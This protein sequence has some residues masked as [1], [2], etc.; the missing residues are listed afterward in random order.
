MSKVS[1]NGALEK[2]GSVAVG[3]NAPLGSI[4]KYLK[5]IINGM[6]IPAFVIDIN[7]VVIH[8]NKA[9][10]KLTGISS[11]DMIGTQNAWKAF[12]KNERPVL[13]DL[14]V[15]DSSEQLIDEY[16]KGRVSKSRLID[17]AYVAQGYFS[18]LGNRG[19]WLYFTATPLKDDSGK[20][21]G[22]VETF[23]D[24]TEQRYAEKQLTES[25]EKLRMITS[26]AQDAII[27]IDDQGKVSFWNESAQKIFGFSESEILGEN[28]HTVL[29]P[30]R[31]HKRFEESFPS[32]IISGK[33]PYL[34]KISEMMAVNKSG[35]EFP[36]E[37]SLSAVKIQDNW[38]SI[39]IIRDIT[40]RKH[41]E[42]ELRNSERRAKRQRAAIVELTLGENILEKDFQ[43]SL[44]K[45]CE[46]LSD[47]IGVS[48]TSVWTLADD[49]AELHCLNLYE[50][51]KK[52]HT[53]GATLNANDIP[54]YFNAIKSDSCI[55]AEDVQ[56]DPR[57]DE[58]AENYLKPLGI[59]SMLDAGIVIEG[60]LFGVIC[61][62]HIGN[63]RK[64]HHDEESFVST[65][66]A[67]VAQLII[68][69]KRK[70]AEK[71]LRESEAK[72]RELTDMLPQVIFETDAKGNLTFVNRNAFDTFGYRKD[73][74][75]S[76]LNAIQ[77]IA[78]KDRER[79]AASMQQIIAGQSKHSGREYTAI[80]KDGTEFPVII[81]S[82][83]FLRDGGIAGLRGLIV[84]ISA[85]KQAEQDKKKL[86]HQLSQA[87]KMEA[88]GRLAGG[89]A[90]DYNNML[91][92]ILGH[93]DM[94]LEQVHPDQPIYTDI[95]EIKQAGE[96]SVDLTRQLLAF[97][98]KQTVVPEELN[99]NKIVG[100]MIKML[101]RLIGEDIDLVW[102]PGEN[103]WTVRVDPSQIDQMVVNLCVNARDAIS[104][105]GRISIET[106]NTVFDEDY[107]AD[108]AGF[109]PGEYVLLA[110]SDDGCGMD[111]E[112]RVNVFEPFFTTKD[113]GKGTGLGLSTIY[114]TV[115]QNQGFINLYSEPGHGTT[116]K[117]YLPRLL[118]KGARLT[119]RGSLQP[120]ERGHETILL[121]EDEPA[122]LRMTTL[123]LKKLGYTVIAAKNPAE[124]IS[125]AR[126]HAGE[127][128]LLLTDVIM[129]EMNGR[130]LAKR[131]LSYYPSLKRLFMSGYTADVIAHHGVLEKGVNFI[132]KP[133]SKEGLGAKVRQVLD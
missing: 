34:N 37:L 126:E 36:I 95:T 27:M 98:R 65:I 102:M 17:D 118:M 99:L 26:S 106:K 23:Q 57:T 127:I 47:T 94:I 45:V 51:G 44:A 13:A 132:Q 129:P 83:R 20:K 33:G 15:D 96:R 58:L 10:E 24:F 8:W 78:V 133:F 84:D 48:R 131:I 35:N 113:P 101:G 54:K 50:T 11:T 49:G 56:N 14:I 82:T 85:R 81:Y 68:E 40:E 110:V 92:V 108:H 61:A 46:I 116:F 19:K 121:V 87:Q 28:L 64:W 105:V 75:T 2:L 69:S 123:M 128:H 73:E 9:C 74:F 125:L 104:D 16:Y 32:F 43:S 88:I 93:T 114:G 39:G 29:A 97:A 59:T 120:A 130:E 72:F 18:H 41:I 60:R 115:K 100:G 38:H 107:C 1:E 80:R 22:A 67:F 25:E 77:M 91:G 7:H 71:E 89:V 53:Q 122:I 5:Q 79:A 4:E 90:H 6:A 112:T 124:A 66:A 62:E 70:R 111:A 117:I 21:I 109:E 119:A 3:T 103:L 42:Q 76:E 55:F 31:F 86:E 12:Y 30:R 52:A 63:M